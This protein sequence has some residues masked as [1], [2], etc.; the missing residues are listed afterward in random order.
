MAGETKMTGYDYIEQPLSEILKNSKFQRIAKINDM[1]KEV[2]EEK[3]KVEKVPYSKNS[4]RTG[5]LAHI[6]ANLKKLSES[7][8]EELY[9]KLS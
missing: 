3:P 7:E 9:K 1:N 8:I 6:H 4:S 5:M 2:T